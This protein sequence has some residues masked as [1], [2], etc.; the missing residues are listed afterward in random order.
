MRRSLGTTL[1][2]L[3]QLAEA[4][5]AASAFTVP[6]PGRLTELADFGANPGNLRCWSFVPKA[7]GPLPLV[8][9]LHG[10]TQT[11]AGYDL[12]S[13]W[14]ELAERH[15]FAVLFAEQQRANNANL[16]FNWFERGDTARGS[17]EAK[18]IARMVEKLA[19][20]GTID[21]E[22]IF[23]TGLSAGGA[24]T[25]VMLATYPDLFS[26]GAIIAGL[27]YGAASTVPQA[28]E[29]MRGEG[30]LAPEAA[31][32]LVSKAAPPRDR[33]PTVSVWHGTADAT[34][35]P[36]NAAA[37]VDQWRAL[38]GLLGEPA[39]E[40][41]VDGYPRRQWCDGEGRVAVEEYVVTGMGHGTPI[42]STGD[43]ALGTAMPFML[44]VGISSTSHIA[45]SWG[46]IGAV[47]KAA[48]SQTLT[49]SRAVSPAAAATPPVT[50][51]APVHGVQAT[52]EAALRSA[53][54]MR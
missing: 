50:V 32:A 54:L 21:R 16:C 4:G 42:D 25:A 53:G 8:V 49:E 19:A 33:W 30:L 17:G 46:L 14:S 27:P 11:A 34:V 12:G 43:A 39:I 7:D 44:D 9:V 10:C 41:T 3:K 36:T 29:R 20:R 38:N 51:R 18:S 23:V 13:G 31:A 48:K 2:G 52:I 6:G 28:F 47:R 1:S 5:R 22:R 26:G 24:M 15:G 37:I 35:A 45:A 40:E